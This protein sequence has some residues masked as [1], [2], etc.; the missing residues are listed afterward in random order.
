[1]ILKDLFES[2]DEEAPV[3]PAAPTEETPGYQ[4]PDDDVLGAIHR[5]NSHVPNLSLRV[6]NSMKK[7]M[8]AKQVEADRRKD[9]MAIM[10]TA[11]ASEE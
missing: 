2:D 7:V 1:M 6:I 10:Y 8:Q 5:D 9:L 3:N 4:N 11:P